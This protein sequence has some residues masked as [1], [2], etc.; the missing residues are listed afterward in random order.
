LA[1]AVVQINTWKDFRHL[2][3]VP[4]RDGSWTNATG[5]LYLPE[6]HDASDSIPEGISVAIIDAN[7]ASDPSRR[8]LYQ[9]LDACKL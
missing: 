1:Q 3:L 4:L 9:K 8:E 2:N 5:R 6:L 7:A